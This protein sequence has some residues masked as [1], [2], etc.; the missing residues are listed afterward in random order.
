MELGLVLKKCRLRAKMTQEELAEKAF[1]ARSA[2]SKIENNRQVI[3][4]PLLITWIQMTG[5]VDIFIQ[6]INGTDISTILSMM[7]TFWIL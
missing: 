4:A 1:L 6:I 7:F 2:I 3:D 5:A